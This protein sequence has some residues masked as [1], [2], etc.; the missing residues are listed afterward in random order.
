MSLFSM[1]VDMAMD[2]IFPSADSISGWCVCVC[3]GGN[4][5]RCVG[6]HWRGPRMHRHV[7]DV[8]SERSG[9]P[10]LFDVG[11]EF[12]DTALG[13]KQSCAMVISL[14]P[15]PNVSDGAHGV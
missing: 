9:P 12:C 2:F 13:G 8:S 11:G 5:P 1:W 10:P 4:F 6:R 3:G 15:A 7:S 14:P